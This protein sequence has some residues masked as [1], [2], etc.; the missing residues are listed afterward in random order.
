MY[1]HKLPFNSIREQIR[2]LY[3]LWPN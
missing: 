1:I 2:L 3:K